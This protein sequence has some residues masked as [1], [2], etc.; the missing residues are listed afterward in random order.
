M[1]K[2]KLVPVFGTDVKLICRFFVSLLKRAIP[3]TR[4]PAASK[5]SAAR[6]HFNKAGR[7]LN[8]MANLK[9]LQ[10]NGRRS[11]SDDDPGNPTVN[12]H[13]ERLSNETHVST[14]EADAQLARKGEGKEAKLSYS[15]NLLVE[16]R[17]GLI[18]KA[19]VAQGQPRERFEGQNQGMAKDAVSANPPDQIPLILIRRVGFCGRGSYGYRCLS[20]IMPGFCGATEV[21]KG[22]YG[23]VS[24]RC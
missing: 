5:N 15:G 10:P 21:S 3:P 23:R 17:N 4:P 12:F 11:D 19:K 9:S 14:T 22:Y 18:L 20:K 24:S 13:G 2:E 7:D 1:K 6:A 16:N 8:R